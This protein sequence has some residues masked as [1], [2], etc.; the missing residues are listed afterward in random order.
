MQ[1]IRKEKFMK[2]FQKHYLRK[3]FA[4]VMAFL[5]II[6]MM[7]V[8]VFAEEPQIPGIATR[9]VDSEGKPGVNWEFKPGEKDDGASNWPLKSGARIIHGLSLIHI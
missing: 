5:M 4:L 6:T 8:N 3:T 2:N 9:G 1:E 7:P